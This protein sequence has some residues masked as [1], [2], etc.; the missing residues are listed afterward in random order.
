MTGTA[1]DIV[2][3]TKILILAVFAV[4]GLIASGK[5]ASM[6]WLQEGVGSLFMAAALVFVAYEGF[7]LITNAVQE[8]DDPKRNVPRGVYA[9]IGIVTA[10]YVVLAYVAVVALP[11]DDLVAAREYALAAVAQPVLG[12]A[13]R[14]LVGV[15]ALLATSSAINST[16]FGASRMMA[17]MGTDGKMP[18][19]VAARNSAAVPWVALTVLTGLGLALTVFGSLEVIAAF[20]S[21]TFLLVSLAVSVANL[22]IHGQTRARV[23]LVAA[24]IALL[25]AT[26]ALLV[27][28]LATNQ[29]GI[30][31]LV[32]VLYLLAFAAERSYALWAKHRAAT[33]W[34]GGSQD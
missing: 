2:V 13:G 28:Y 27:F 15:A 4:A 3:Y 20:S 17:D 5:P 23:P 31:G 12:E 24:G 16:V 1:E 9:S 25:V 33:T 18:H 8:T 14:L 32:V 21:M 7:Q 11:I 29:P 10:I 26:I 6:P 30:L 34:S 19:V 22:R